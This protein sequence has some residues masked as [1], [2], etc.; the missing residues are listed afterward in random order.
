MT[1]LPASAGGNES[2][3]EVATVADTRR[4]LLDRT[5]RLFTPL[6]KTFVQNPDRAA[7]SRRGPLAEFVNKGDHRGLLAFL[8]IHT[9]ISNGT[10]GWNTTLHLEVWARAFATI[11]HAT[12][13]SA[14]SAASKVLR[15][16]EERSL[17]EREQSGRPKRIKVT[18]LMPDG[19]GQPYERPL[20]TSRETRFIRLSHRFWTD[21]WDQMLSLPAIAMLLVALHEKP[22]FSLA[23]EH[24][25]DWYGWSADTAERGLRELRDHGLLEATQKSRKEPLAPAGVT[26]FNQYTLRAP[27]DSA[28]LD[29]D[30]AAMT[31]RGQR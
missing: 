7:A 8:L 3:A 20:G 31:H 10:N 24:M 13:T 25:P 29:N 23:T 28:T 21:G 11:E 22:T 1:T 18:V 12:P 14:K 26:Y 9:A 6:A 17:I 16:L 15:R 2:A 5:N 30:I 4:A 19:T 27:F